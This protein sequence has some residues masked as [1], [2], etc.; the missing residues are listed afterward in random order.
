MKTFML[1]QSKDQVMSLIPDRGIKLVQLGTNKICVS[2]IGNEFFAFETLCP[3]QKT[4]LHQGQVT[5]LAEVI[6][7]LHHFRFDLYTGQ[8]RSGNCAALKIFK[9]SLIDGGL[10]IKV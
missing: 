8:V 6:C 3:H 4:P 9:T 7:P 10:E 1:G 5:G 2:R